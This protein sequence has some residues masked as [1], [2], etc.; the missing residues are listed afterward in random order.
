MTGMFAAWSRKVLIVFIALVGCAALSLFVATAVKAEQM[1]A[2]WY[3]PGFEGATTASGEPFDPYDYTAASLTYEFGTRLIVTYE[4]RSV[5]VRVTD[6]GPYVAGRDLDLS[7]GA[8]EYIGLTAVGVGT[9]D[10]EV[11][12]PSTPTGPY[13]GTREVRRQQAPATQ[14][15]EP[16][17]DTRQAQQEPAAD[18][19]QAGAALTEGQQQEKAQQD[20]VGTGEDQYA[21]ADQYKDEIVVQEAV[22]P[23]PPAP[24][25]AVPVLPPEPEPAA[26]EAPPVELAVPNSTIERRVELNVAAPPAPAPAEQPVEAAAT[27]ETAKPVAEEA[28]KPVAEEAVKPVVQEAPKPAVK[29]AP[30]PVVQESPKPAVQKA[31]EPVVEEK[32]QPEKTASKKPEASGPGGITV[33]PDTGGAPLGAIGLLGGAVLLG[34][35]LTIRIARR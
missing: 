17:Q 9:V 22:P 1:V 21:S 5:V 30:E 19:D 18:A 23:A 34:A 28:A 33:L 16:A 27:E 24:K 6:L 29:K 8:A 25:P 2:S 14:P 32:P 31:P 10:V 20:F 26:L 11:A 13:G 7:Q 3:G 12:A 4:G 35:G 15:E